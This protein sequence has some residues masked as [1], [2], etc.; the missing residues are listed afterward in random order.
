ML[1][2]I[3]QA[4]H[5]IWLSTYIFQTDPVGLEFVYALGAAITRGVKVHVL[6]DGIGEWYDWPHVTPLLRRAVLI[7]P[8]PTATYFPAHTLIKLPKSSKNVTH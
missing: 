4:K 3:A 1:A 8:L 5:S 6:V 7:P 2:A